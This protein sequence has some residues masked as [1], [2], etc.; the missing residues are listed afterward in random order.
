MKL[1]SLTTRTMLVGASCLF[2][3]GAALAQ[4]APDVGL[5]AHDDGSPSRLWLI[6]CG[7]LRRIPAIGYVDLMEQALPLIATAHNVT[8][9]PHREPTGMP[10]RTHADYIRALRWHYRARRQ[11]PAPTDPLAED[12]EPLFQL[13]EA[14]VSIS[15]DADVFDSVVLAGARVESGATIVRCVVCPG[16]VV[17][18]RERLMN[19][20]VAGGDRR[21]RA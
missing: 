7:C 15:P 10:L 20:L 4:Q 21:K 1:F 3:S 16:G 12:W 9:T 17:H 18:R 13:S 11:G 6:R 8:V 2:L 5:I 19:Q 14:G